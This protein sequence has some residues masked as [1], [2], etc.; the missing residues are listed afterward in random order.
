MSKSTLYK[1]IMFG[2][3]MMIFFSLAEL[4]KTCK[5]ILEILSNQ[6]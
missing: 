5:A 2:V 1:L 4:V 6:T 3:A